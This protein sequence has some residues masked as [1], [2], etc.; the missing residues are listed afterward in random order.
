[1]SRGDRREAISY[2]DA[3]R[4]EFLRT[5]V[6]TWLKTE[7]QAHAYCLM[8]NYFHL[9]L[10][11]PQP[12]LA[13]GMK[14][15]LGTY[16]QRFNRRHRHSGHFFGGRYK[17]WGAL[18]MFQICSAVSMVSSDPLFFLRGSHPTYRLRAASF[19]AE[20]GE[21]AA[22]DEAW[23]SLWMREYLMEWALV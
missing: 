4:A 18:A 11:T 2:R 5:L 13:N 12:N 23:E 3:D 9:V 19:M 17:E 6:Q 21:D 15:L 8:S 16:A 10:E 1:M 7:W 20:S 22:W 14:W